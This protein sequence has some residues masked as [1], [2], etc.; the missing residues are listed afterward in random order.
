MKKILQFT[1]I[2]LFL[3]GSFYSCDKNDVST[4]K[5]TK[6][7]LVGIVDAQTGELQVLEPNNCEEC[8]TLTF[9]T[10]S[11]CRGNS[12]SNLIV[13][14]FDVNYKTSAFCISNIGGTEICEIL[15]GDLYRNTLYEVQSFFYTENALILYFNENKNY[16]LFS[17]WKQ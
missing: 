3:A 5:G 4:L 11:M 2:M 6:W 17:T 1:A 14:K 13:V 15:D 8:Y 9:E 16:L 12:S 7:K 10:D